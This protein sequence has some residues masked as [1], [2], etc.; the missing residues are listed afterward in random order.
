MSTSPI[1]TLNAHLARHSQR[2]RYDA[3]PD[4]PRPPRDYWERLEEAQAEHLRGAAEAQQR[5][6]LQHVDAR[7]RAHE[8]MHVAAAGVYATGGPSYTYAIGPDG[9]RYAVGGSVG[10]DLQPV[11]G[12]PEATIRKMRAIRR[13]ATAP[14]Q[15]SRADMRVAAK[16][17]RLEQ[18][19]QQKIDARR[20]DGTRP[21]PADAGIGRADPDGRAAPGD[22][23]APPVDPMAPGNRA[24]PRDPTAPPGSRIDVAA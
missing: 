11:P 19:A 10:V 18:E 24:A 15:P 20:G 21:G 12:N 7:V 16:A 9:Q 3:L 5:R 2:P 17:Y 6:E 13:A 8:A 4:P 1:T 23:T 22:R 14:G